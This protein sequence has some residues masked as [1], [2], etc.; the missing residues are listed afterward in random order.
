MP[1]RAPTEIP[2]EASP[3]APTA[4]ALVAA[5]P[6]I[7]PPPA[8]AVTDDFLRAF[9]VPLPEPAIGA[10]ALATEPSLPAPSTPP[11]LAEETRV[12]AR[13]QLV[14]PPSPQPPALP[15]EAHESSPAAATAPSPSAREAERESPHRASTIIERR[16][17]VV[18]EKSG[19]GRAEG[20][21]SGAGAP[22]FGLGQL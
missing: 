20:P 13:A 5:A 21:S 3:M 1:E 18:V 8:L 2:T 10:E 17:V 19:T 14:M 11:A 22:H 16:Q 6:P 12:T 15:P 7:H 4:A 9:G